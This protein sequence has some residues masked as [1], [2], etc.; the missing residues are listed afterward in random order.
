MAYTDVLATE[1]APDAGGAALAGRRRAARS[2]WALLAPSLLLMAAFFALPLAFVVWLTGTDGDGLLGNVGWYLGDPVQRAVLVRTF[3]TAGL[4]TATCAVVGYGY[5]Y[6]MVTASARARMVLTI[7]VL[8]PFWTSLMVRTFAWVIL[9]QDNGLINS[10]LD[11]LGL[12]RVA[13]IRTTGGVVVGMA[14]ILLPMMVMPIYSAMLRIDRGLLSA[15][16]TLGARPAVTFARVWLP[17]SLPGVAAGSLLVFISSLGFYVTPALLGSPDS[18]L[19]S[20]QIYAQ[21]SG[22]LAWGRGGVMGLSLLVVTGVLLSL[23][24]AVA[25]SFRAGRLRG[26]R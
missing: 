3:T 7:I 18:S 24:F 12:G 25:A 11:G 15:S 16:A 17:L 21:V 8:M 6:L 2:W 1:A 26:S 19:V 9:L 20:Q 10:L 4:V 5:A 23:A 14:Q 13:L 22:L